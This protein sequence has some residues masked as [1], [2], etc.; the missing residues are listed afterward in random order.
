MRVIF[1]LS[2]AVLDGILRI[3]SVQH[4]LFISL[5]FVSA[6]SPIL[7]FMEPFI[8]STV[9]A[10]FSPQRNIEDASPTLAQE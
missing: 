10:W 5:L 9:K 4:S 7:R 3:Q 8:I 2:L 6:S 1:G